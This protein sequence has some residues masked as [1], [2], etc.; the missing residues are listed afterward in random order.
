MAKQTVGMMYDNHR[1]SLPTPKFDGTTDIDKFIHQ[2]EK[3]AT[4]M[5]WGDEEAAIRFQMT[6]SGAAQ[7][8]LTTTTFRGMCTQLRSRYQ[9]SEN[10]AVVLLKAL[11]W[12]TNDSV[13]EFAAYVKQ[14]VEKAFPELD[15]SQKEK[16]TIK[17]LTN[18]LPPSCH[19]LTWELRNRTPSSYEEV[20]ELVQDFSEMNLGTTR[21][22]RIET[23][24]I[25]S[26][27]QEVASQAALISKMVA[28]QTEIQQQLAAALSTPR[29]RRD[30]PSIIC[31]RCQQPGHIAR[32]CTNM[33]KPNQEKAS[34]N[35]HVRQSHA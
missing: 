5:R 29:P 2:F 22:N 20:V 23:D 11:K 14:L 16:R 31:Y 24:E 9:L 4:L 32:N 10:G 18:A 15:P 21:V 28:T 17:E 35:A 33:P 34:E 6:I 30:N 25:A 27:R 1:P 19:I 3:V 7:K 8:G 13:H 12:K 26:L